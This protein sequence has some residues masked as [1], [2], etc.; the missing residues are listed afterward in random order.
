[1]ALIADPRD[2][3][4][5]LLERLFQSAVGRAD[6][7][8]REVAT[9]KREMLLVVAATERADA[10][11]REVATLKE[12]NAKLRA[13]LHQ[14]SLNS[15]RPPS[16]DG[17]EVKRPPRKPKGRR[18]GGQPGHEGAE[19]KLL[20]PDKVVDH[21]P[22]RCRQ[23]A[24]RLA[25]KD[26]DP[27]RFQLL[28][29]PE[30]RPH[31]T[32]HRGHSLTCA[33]CGTVTR[34][35]LPSCVLEHG[36]GPRLTGLVAYLS[37]FGRLS[38]RQVVELC[39]DAFGTPI[40]LGAVCAL[41]QDVA[42]ALVAPVEEARAAVRRQAVVY[43][44]ET[45]WREDK[46]LAWLWVV[47]T[48]VAIVF[49]VARG[50]GK[51]VVKEI[52]GENF[53]GRLVTDRWRAYNWFDV[54]RRQLC[55][56]HLLR[57]FQGMVEREG[58]GSEL[59][60]KLRNEAN[61]MFVWWPQVRDGTLLRADFQLRMSPVRVEVGR[62][63][64]DAADRAEPR[65]AGMCADILKLEPALWTFVDVEAIEPTNN[66]SE[67]TIRPAVL[68]R[69][70]CFGNDSASGSRFT[71]RVLTAV[72]TVRLRRGNVLRYLTEACAA[73]RE[74]RVAPSLLTVAAAA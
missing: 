21:I 74:N 8:E 63:L 49:Q 50:R 47:V 54:R 26:L 18:R 45:G 36:F 7:L 19:R 15:S 33:A 71:E 9:L 5:A 6:E 42:V 56:A 41:E 48:S 60:V 57:D 30:I 34:E 52:L 2:A 37:G 62:L 64:R 39:Q 59:A 66:I 69:K 23:C 68:W 17:P 24:H 28:E 14:S 27:T 65:T 61:E 70:G 3:R 12:E 13:Q 35:P 20:P 16:T 29:L 44:D 46:K 51:A 58:I 72:A 25:G 10:L 1:V 22:K 4:I 43:M 38:K 67:R 11:S 32:E 31:V 53:P 55:W 40:S 73:H